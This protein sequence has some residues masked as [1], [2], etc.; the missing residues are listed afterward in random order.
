MI[1]TSFTTLF[2]NTA[3]LPSAASPAWTRNH[4]E[5]R[6]GSIGH[7][8]WRV[9][10]VLLY[11]EVWQKNYH[12]N[13]R[14]RYPSKHFQSYFEAAGGLASVL[15]SRITER[16]FLNFKHSGSGPDWF[17]GKGVMLTRGESAA[18]PIDFYNT[19]L[20][21]SAGESEQRTR[22]AQIGEIVEFMKKHSSVDTPVV[23]AGDMNID[24]MNTA[25]TDYRDMM[26]CLAT[27]RPVQDANLASGKAPL[28]TYIGKSPSWKDTRLDYIF[29][30]NPVQG[31]HCLEVAG[32][33]HLAF[34]TP[35]S[36]AYCTVP[37]GEEPKKCSLSDHGGIK[38]DFRTTH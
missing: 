3:L 24:G 17:S 2:F 16:D 4:P 15:K 21:A 20:Q 36:T 29:L 26:E 22:L 8:S 35:P 38:A 23:L 19:H 11:C 33:D 25:G 37:G 10:E 32:F 27:F 1:P 6:A 9:G 34:Q 5:E 28:S 31:E 7:D 13:L 30:F 18:G 14:H 12:D